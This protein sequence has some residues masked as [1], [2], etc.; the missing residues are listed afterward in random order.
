MLYPLISLDLQVEPSGMVFVEGE[1]GSI[2]VLRIEVRRFHFYDI[3]V[4]RLVVVL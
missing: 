1:M 4:V 3:G 2:F